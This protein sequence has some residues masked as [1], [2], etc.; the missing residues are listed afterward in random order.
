MRRLLVLRPEPGASATLERASR[1][2]FD[3]FSVPLFE[4]E[5]LDWAAPDPSSFDA[6]LLTSANAVFQ[7]GK[8]LEAFRGLPV[9]AVGE[10]TANAARAHGFA[11]ETTGEGSL[12]ELLKRVDRGEKL[13]HL[14]A[15]HRHS[16]PSSHTIF[17][18]EVY[19]ALAI[20]C[21]D[22]SQAQGCV[23]LIHSPR[24]ARRFAELIDVRGS[25]AIAAISRAAAQASQSGWAAL[26]FA[27]EPSDEGL[28]ALASRLCDIPPLQ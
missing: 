13:L 16:S 2:G 6:L 10:A 9:C 11:V 18:V 15:K 24:A 7:A 1:L 14:C 8:K 19:Q 5:P 17:E 3:V 26:E 22:L 21:P 23:A 27:S 28:L 20:D 4:V 12:E 25:I